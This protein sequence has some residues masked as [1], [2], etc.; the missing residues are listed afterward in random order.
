MENNNQTKEQMRES[1]Y[2]IERLV[3]EKLTLESEREKIKERILELKK[4][5]YGTV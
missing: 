4:K 3:Y 1:L 2:E 5:I